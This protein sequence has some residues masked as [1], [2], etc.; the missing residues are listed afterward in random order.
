[1]Q[2]KFRFFPERKR[3]RSLKSVDRVSLPAQQQLSSARSSVQRL[4]LQ[5]PLSVSQ[6]QFSD[7]DEDTPVAAA[8]GAVPSSPPPVP[9]P[10]QR[11]KS[12]ASIYKFFDVGQFL[13]GKTV[14][15]RICR[16]YLLCLFFLPWFRH[17]LFSCLMCSFL[18]SF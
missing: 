14:E 3:S 8:V 1:M 13:V 9:P 18:D 17:G 11:R 7:D 16:V 12:M 2:I 6:H 4:L 5:N 10:R 15:R